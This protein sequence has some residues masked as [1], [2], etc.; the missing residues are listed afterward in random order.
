MF[1]TPTI[2]FRSETMTAKILLARVLLDTVIDHFPLQENMYSL[3]QSDRAIHQQNTEKNL[4]RSSRDFTKQG[5]LRS[6]MTSLRKVPSDK[7]GR[8]SISPTLASGPTRRLD[9][10]P[11]SI[12]LAQRSF[13]SLNNYDKLDRSGTW[14]RELSESQDLTW[15]R[16]NTT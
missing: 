6:W 7:R 13:S 10:F 8:S 12:L 2:T 3:C 1:W 4:L 14:R 11:M 15:V 9:I 16:G 5:P